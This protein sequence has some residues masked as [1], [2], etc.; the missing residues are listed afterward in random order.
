MIDAVVLS[1]L[2]NAT[3]NGIYAAALYRDA[4]GWGSKLGFEAPTLDQ[5]F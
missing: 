3:L 1:A 4:S 2:D 5:A